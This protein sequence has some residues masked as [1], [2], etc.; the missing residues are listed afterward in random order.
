MSKAPQPPTEIVTLPDEIIADLRKLLF[1]RKAIYA[2]DP[3][4]FMFYLASTSC[5]YLHMHKHEVGSENPKNPVPDN[6]DSFFELYFKLD[7]DTRPKTFQFQHH[8]DGKPVTFFTLN[9]RPSEPYP[10][11]LIIHFA[12]WQEWLLKESVKQM[13]P[14]GYITKN[15]ERKT[16]LTFEKYVTKHAKAWRQLPR[17]VKAYPHF[18]FHKPE[19]AKQKVVQLGD[20]FG[21]ISRW[22][23]NTDCGTA[24][25][26]FI[27][28]G[29][30]NWYQRWIGLSIG[31]TILAALLYVMW[32][33]MPQN[34]LIHGLMTFF[35]VP[36][37]LFI[38][39]F[40]GKYLY[41]GHFKEYFTRNP[42]VTGQG[43]A[44]YIPEYTIEPN[45]T[46]RAQMR[47]N[48]WMF[49]KRF[50]VYSA[51]SG[52]A[53][54]CITS[55][56]FSLGLH[57]TL[58]LPLA[59]SFLQ[60]V[61]A[62]LATPTVAITGLVFSL[63][64]FLLYYYVL[65]PTILQHKRDL[66][67]RGTQVTLKNPPKRDDGVNQTHT[68]NQTLPIAVAVRSDSS[69]PIVGKPESQNPSTAGDHNKFNADRGLPAAAA[70]AADDE[71]R[72]SKSKP[73]GL[74]FQK[75]EKPLTDFTPP[76]HRLR[77]SNSAPLPALALHA[78][79][80]SDYDPAG[81]LGRESSPSPVESDESDEPISQAAKAVGGFDLVEGGAESQLRA[82]FFSTT[83]VTMARTRSEGSAKML[84]GKVT[85]AF[86]DLRKDKDN[87]GNAQA[88][89]DHTKPPT[90]VQ[91]P[92]GRDSGVSSDAPSYSSPA[93]V[94]PS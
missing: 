70:A 23:K 16:A 21:G 45:S 1:P 8:V 87:A 73:R 77:R 14:M 39:V 44:E 64:L 27:I 28:D 26:N 32:G 7:K 89:L 22:I 55:L 20:G 58:D 29:S 4:A 37:C 88:G 66:K 17:E 75:Q 31:L 71:N 41:S 67:G 69:S 18:N 6:E 25:R 49:V 30:I 62:I 3:N 63:F 72:I 40:I 86:H 42:V 10:R 34:I 59:L 82:R 74:P 43:T 9:I 13:Q 68:R 19:R 94:F 81:S 56:V 51:I 36:L 80:P 92:N 5:Y 46:M 47:Q 53:A 11:E 35:A 33:V 57:A 60:P 79:P 78:Q 50:F 52:F 15:N 93:N 61:A 12:D 54:L 84:L 76:R 2:I 38:G 90:T 91:D 24:E 85:H 65:E 48:P 83:P